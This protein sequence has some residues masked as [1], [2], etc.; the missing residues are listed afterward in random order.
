MLPRVDKFF[1]S[2]KR[3]QD[4]TYLTLLLRKILD[5]FRERVIILLWDDT[6]HN[7]EPSLYLAIK[8]ILKEGYP[9]K[10]LGIYECGFITKSPNPSEVV[11][12]ASKYEV[13]VLRPFETE[14]VS[15]NQVFRHRSFSFF[16]NYS[17]SWRDGLNFIYAGTQVFPLLS[18][19]TMLEEYAP[20]VVV[21][22]NRY[23]AGDFIKR[24]L[25][26]KFMNEEKH[27]FTPQYYPEQRIISCYNWWANLK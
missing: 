10:G 7:K 18:V 2:T 22:R 9:I 14:S 12:L 26:D 27:S 19:Q 25:H 3:T 5:Y 24:K 11:N 8:K 15:F 13:F 4:T 23:L 1:I 6:F 17:P 20:W 21:G 16:R